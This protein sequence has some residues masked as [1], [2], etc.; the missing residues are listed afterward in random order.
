M[1]D[2]NPE[3]SRPSSLNTL[4]LLALGVAVLGLSALAARTLRGRVDGRSPVAP[5]G[6]TASPRDSTALAK[7]GKLLYQL[8]CARCHGSEGHGDGPD[9]AN[10]QPPPR[11]FASTNW[12]FDPG[13]ESIRGVIVKGIPGTSMYPMGGSFSPRELD[14]LVEHVRSLAPKDR[15]RTPQRSL[16]PDLESE[17]KAAGF[18]PDSPLKRAP[19]VEVETLEG[20][21][22]SLD[23]GRGGRLTLLVFWGTSCAPCQE[24]LPELEALAEG[25]RDRGLEVVPVCVDEADRIVVRRVIRGKFEKFPSFVSLDGMAR[26]LYDVQTL[27]AAALI[28][29][30]GNLMGMARGAVDWRSEEARRLIQKSLAGADGALVGSATRSGSSR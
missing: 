7:R 29:R 14:A 15:G 23:F 28:D 30:E 18:V 24:E 27:P 1:T 5:V 16:S 4:G 9:S 10:I 20:A 22:R 11:D 17:L 26:L 8:Q 25:F 3:P 19:S 2:A 13:P 12:R 21:R 6:I